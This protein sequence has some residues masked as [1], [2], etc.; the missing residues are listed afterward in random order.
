[1]GEGGGSIRLMVHGE[2]ERRAHGVRGGRGE[3]QQV[4]NLALRNPVPAYPVHRCHLER[5]SFRED[6]RGFSSNSTWHFGTRSQRTRYIGARLN[7]RAFTNIC[8]FSVAV[9]STNGKPCP[10]H[11][12]SPVSTLTPHPYTKHLKNQA[13][14]WFFTFTFINTPFQHHGNI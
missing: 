1:M 12:T 3:E 9:N 7:K 13:A 11:Q 4:V 6:M 10:K 14:A 5:G 8:E 2:C